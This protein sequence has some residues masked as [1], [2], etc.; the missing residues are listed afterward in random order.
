M[1]AILRDANTVTCVVGDSE[2]EST[3]IDFRDFSSGMIV[4]VGL[5]S[6]DTATSPTSPVK[7]WVSSDDSTFYLLVDKAGA[8]VELITPLHSEF[9][10][11]PDEVF[12][13]HFVKFV[14]ASTTA[15]INCKVLLKG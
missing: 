3:S 15:D 12:A 5:V 11:F 2:A 1:T 9:V 8:D 13:A 14:S 10:A 4:F 7:I 6:D